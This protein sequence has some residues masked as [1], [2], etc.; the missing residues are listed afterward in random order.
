MKIW[1]ISKYA[2]PNEFGM[3]TR[4]FSLSKE[5]NTKSHETIVITS[6]SQ[7]KGNFP[8]FKRVYNNIIV[9][10]VNTIFIKTVKFRSAYSFRRVISWI[11]FEL[12]LLFMNKSSLPKPDRIIVSSLSLFTVLSGLYLRRR[13]KSKLILEIRDIWPKTIIDIGNFNPNNLFVKILSWI[14]KI[15]Y[16][17]YDLIISTLPNFQE[18][19]QTVLKTYKKVYCVP[20]GYNKDYFSGGSELSPEYKELIPKNKFIVGYAG[21]VGTS[22]ALDTFFEAAINMENSEDIHFL[23]LGWGDKLEDFKKFTSKLKNITFLPK[24]DKNQ[25]QQVIEN[26][27]VLYDSVKRIDLYKFGLSR[28][29]WIDYMYA[30][31]PMIISYSGYES[32]VNEAKC[33]VFIEAENTKALTDKI[34][35]FRHLGSNELNAMGEKGKRWLLKNRSYSKLADEFLSIIR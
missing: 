29:K 14:E 18:H 28:N 7:P 26:C 32:M 19:V 9:D 30:S 13:Y 15:G 20:Q 4:H 24:V 35:E 23:V 12:K 1:Y 16:K 17:N 11:D 34:I 31:K 3:A 8:K 25:V 21:A 2:R 27:N 5:F 6:D 10:E 22:N 33:G